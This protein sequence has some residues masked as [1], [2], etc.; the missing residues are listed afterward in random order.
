M[1]VEFLLGVPCWTL[2]DIR[3]A[4]GKHGGRVADRLQVV[5]WV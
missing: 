3:V 2:C 5:E 4:T 1:D